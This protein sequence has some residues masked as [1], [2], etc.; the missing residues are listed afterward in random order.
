MLDID[1][2]WLTI[3]AI[4]HVGIA[5]S[6]ASF[7][8]ANDVLLERFSTALDS[9]N[10]VVW[11][12]D[13]KGELTE[14]VGHVAMFSG[15]APEDI[16]GQNLIEFVSPDSVDWVL[17][18]LTSQG[19]GG[20][21]SGVHNILHADGPRAA[22]SSFQTVNTRSGVEIRGVTVDISSDWSA[23]E[24]QRRNASIVEHMRDGLIIVAFDKESSTVRID[25]VNPTAQALLEVEDRAGWGNPRRR[26]TQCGQSY[27]EP[28]SYR[29]KQSPSR[30]QMG[31]R[32][33]QL[34]A[35]AMDPSSHL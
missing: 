22:R 2:W 23:G 18:E 3:G 8:L 20:A 35:T 10:M 34:G 7:W 24:A 29:A 26:R 13:S 25:K 6:I 4:F 27:S 31:V 5:L 16:V 1:S 15:I 17:D 21:I 32:N 33:H 9:L 19:K 11:K 14:V 30:R 28:V 12:S